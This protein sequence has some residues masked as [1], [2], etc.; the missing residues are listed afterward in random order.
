MTTTKIEPD[1]LLHGLLNSDYDNGLLYHYD[2]LLKAVADTITSMAPDKRSS[3]IDML[4]N[5]VQR[6]IADNNRVIRD[7]QINVENEHIKEGFVSLNRVKLNNLQSVNEKSECLIRDLEG[8]RRVKAGKKNPL[9]APVIALFC[10]L[11]HESG[12]KKRD[13]YNETIT[14]YC[15]RI[16]ENYNLTYTDR[17]R[18]NF[19]PD[20]TPTPRNI[21][22]VKEL[23]F[24]LIDEATKEAITEYLN[25]KQPPQQKL[26]A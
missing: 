10:K 24:P 21:T 4:K 16:C 3:F 13:T 5:S 20:D 7:L 17:V 14:N 22:K 19:D 6:R 11:L 2:E 25:S 15:I 23:I 8:L 18:Q 12:F 1:S 26:Y 9:S